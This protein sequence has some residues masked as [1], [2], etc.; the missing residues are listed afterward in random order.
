MTVLCVDIG[1]SN[2]VLGLVRELRIEAHWR[3]STTESRTS[4]EWAMLVQALLARKAEP[5]VGIAVCSAV[6]SVLH[7]WRLMLA[8]YF[9]SLPQVIVE[10]GVRTGMPILVDNPREVGADRIVNSLAAAQLFPLPAVV[11]DFGTATTFDV[12]NAAGQYVGGAIAPGLEISGQ[13]LGRRGAQ[14]REVELALPRS[15]IGKNTVEALQSGLVYGMACQVDGMVDRIGTELG[16]DT[17]DLS[18]ISTGHLASLVAD[19]CRCFTD[20]EPWLTLKGLDLVF[21]RNH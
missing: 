16:G 5:V 3:V 14:L 18:V 10:P 6:P 11:V 9:A 15:V 8:G 21:E 13:A 17:G 12:I 1:N 7:E 19:Q 20:H 4:D 2:T